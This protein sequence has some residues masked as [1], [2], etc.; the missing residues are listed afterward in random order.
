MELVHQCPD[1]RALR[2][3][4]VS[5]LYPPSFDSLPAWAREHNIALTEAR[6]RFAQYV[7]LRA[8]ANSRALSDF[9]VFKGGNALDFMWQPNR[10]TLDLDFSTARVVADLGREAESLRT[11]FTGA[12]NSVGPGFG[13]LCRIARVEQRPPGSDKTFVTYL[14]RVAYAL[15]DQ[16]SLRQRMGIDPT[17]GPQLIDIEVSINEPICADEPRDIDG[18]HPLRIST[19]EDIVA[20]KLRALLQQ[21]IRKRARPQD[22][23]DIAVVLRQGPPLDRALV[24]DF[25][26]RKAA[27]RTISVSHDAFHHPEIMERARR[28]YD[29]LKGTTR[30]LFVPFEEA[31]ALLYGLVDTLTIPRE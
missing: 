12:L 14:I 20:E 21:P 30:V 8:I 28:G 15:P 13:V 19:V 22:L 29:E 6:R 1:S 18:T 9:L 25:L 10:S 4:R 3:R 11:L 17:Y 24:T 2:K 23:L 26:L 31:R 16:E 7:M 27:A 5:A